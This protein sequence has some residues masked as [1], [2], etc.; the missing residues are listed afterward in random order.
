MCLL[1]P[2]FAVGIP[3]R[4]PFD[5]GRPVGVELF[6]AFPGFPTLIGILLHPPGVAWLKARGLYVW[7]PGPVC[8]DTCRSGARI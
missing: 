7:V 8:V 1:P 3:G 5:A 2:D 4:L 6:L